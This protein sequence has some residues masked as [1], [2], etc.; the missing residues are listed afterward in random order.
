MKLRIVSLALAVLL[1]TPLLSQAFAP[2]AGAQD[3]PTTEAG[4]P[5]RTETAS[6]VAQASSGQ[7]S[8]VDAKREDELVAVVPREG[9]LFYLEIRSAG[10]QAM[11]RSGALT[12]L[13][14]AFLGERRGE[15]GATANTERIASLA[16]SLAANT[17]ARVA[18]AGYKSGSLVGFIEAA[19]NSQAGLLKSALE[20]LRAPGVAINSKGRVV[21]AAMGNSAQ[22]AARK[23]LLFLQADA[24]LMASYDRFAGEPFFGY[25]DLSFTRNSPAEPGNNAYMAGYLMGQSAM[26]QAIAVSG[27]LDG[28]NFVLKAMSASAPRELQGGLPGLFSSILGASSTGQ[29][30]AASFAPADSDVFIDLGIDWDK[31]YDA[32]GSLLSM[33]AGSAPQQSG[34][35]GTTDLLGML[36]TQL[37][38][39][40]RN[41]LIPTLGNEV[42]LSFSGFDSM[43]KTRMPAKQTSAAPPPKRSGGSPRFLVMIALK[44][45]AG[46]EKFFGRF[47]TG[48]MGS[49]SNPF[50]RTPYRNATIVH[51][52]SFA[53]TVTDGFLLAGGSAAEI[54][55]LIDARLSGASLATRAEYRSVI[56]DSS[57]A[58][59]KAYIAPSL[60]GKL[61]DL[62]SKGGS[63]TSASSALKGG[64]GS[65]LNLR[66]PIGV[67]ITH[68]GGRMMTEVR[69]PASLA[70]GLI[71]TL[72]SVKPSQLA[73]TGTAAGLGIPDA[74]GPRT[75]GGRKTP[76]LTDED[77]RRRP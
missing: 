66:A 31:L 67:L 55:K 9:L 64:A 46:F 63:P 27:S 44:D 16:G 1:S 76:T 7:S 38:F 73:A 36:E 20:Q 15:R 2:Q 10:L 60:T 58:G 23:D 6:E 26:P 21:T 12:P 3:K 49:T 52:R 30:V 59:V 39:S 41:D 74:E 37:G 45:P 35:A 54:R 56:P 22:S 13:A 57:Q 62:F 42:A 51:N 71:A 17:S 48:R 72:A 70:Y 77:V 53:Y 11:A 50:E 61:A 32:I 65:P 24:D 19:D 18:L 69:M 40:I 47:F 34:A 25:L 68:E 14:K 8:A 5:R 33:F 28:D 43:V 75:G 29:L 4:R